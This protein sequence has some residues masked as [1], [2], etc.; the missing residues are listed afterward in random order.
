M[1]L[2]SLMAQFVI[3]IGAGCLIGKRAA[4]GAQAREILTTL[5]LDLI[6]PCN[7]VASFVNSRLQGREVLGVMAGAIGY[8]VLIFLLNHFLYR[9]YSKEEQPSL[10]Y[11]TMIPNCAFLG[12]PMCES[13]YGSAGM[14][15]ASMYQIPERIVVWVFAPM[16][17]DRSEGKSLREAMRKMLVN[18]CV[19]AVAIGLVCMLTR[20]HLPEMILAPIQKLG[21]CSTP[22]SMV[23]IGIIFCDIRIGETLNRKVL[24]FCLL[25]LIAIPALVLGLCLPF[26]SLIGEVGFAVVVLMAAL[27]GGTVAVLLASRYKMA[28]RFAS[29]CLVA[30]TLL[31]C[32]T[33]PCWSYLLGVI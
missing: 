2:L 17:F 20:L 16:Y 5:I 14:M 7:I 28:E 26:R 9:A 22:L 18:P 25:R 15:L 24:F 31:S 3:Q 8:S 27:P 19:I 32:L 6:L 29:Q 11:A 13:L 23:M 1:K 30:S 33:L 4:L 12:T 10:K 21:A